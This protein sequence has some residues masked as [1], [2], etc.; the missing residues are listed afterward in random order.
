MFDVGME[1]IKVAAV[2]DVPVEGLSNWGPET[3]R[4]PPEG[5]KRKYLSVYLFFLAA[6]ILSKIV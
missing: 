4:R 3:H 1:A 2:C 5:S 6:C